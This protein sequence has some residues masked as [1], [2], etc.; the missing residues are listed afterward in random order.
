[1]KVINKIY[2][3]YVSNVAM[4]KSGQMQ[5]SF[6]MIFSIILIIVFVCFAGYAIYK[7]MGITDSVK[8]GKFKEEFQ[9]DV[10]ALWK[11]NQGSKAVSYSVPNGVEKVCFIDFTVPA[12]GRDSVVYS[13]TRHLYSETENL[14]F[15][16]VGSGGGLDSTTIEHIDID[17]TTSE[18]N[19]SCIIVENGKMKFTMR[20]DFGS[21]LV[22]LTK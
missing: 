1:M 16:P 15:Y 8:I 20:K 19:P 4:K 6:G 22:T 7:F 14:F 3:L 21:A 13:D 17:E 2:K 11:G 5:L 10:D 18:E 9:T 12:F